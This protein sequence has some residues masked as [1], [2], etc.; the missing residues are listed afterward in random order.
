V[1]LKVPA[2]VK[3]GEYAAWVV[4]TT[5]MKDNV[6]TSKTTSAGGLNANG[7]QLKIKIG[8]GS[9]MK[10]QGGAKLVYRTDK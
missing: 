1:H 10:L 9:G 7:G 2:D 3:P 4:A 6:V 5:E 8:T